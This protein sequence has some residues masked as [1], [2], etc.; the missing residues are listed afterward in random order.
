MELIGIRRP[1][2]VST[3]CSTRYSHGIPMKFQNNVHVISSCME[4]F[5][6]KTGRIFTV[7]L[8]TLKLSKCN[9]GQ[10]TDRS[11]RLFYSGFSDAPYPRCCFLFKAYNAQEICPIGPVNFPDPTPSRFLV[12]KTAHLLFSH[13]LVRLFNRS[14]RTGIFLNK[15]FC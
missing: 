15:N 4:Q 11:S 13:K 10:T 6:K 1:S 5:G 2:K 14:F 3:K 7:S 9:Y 12:L 8:Q